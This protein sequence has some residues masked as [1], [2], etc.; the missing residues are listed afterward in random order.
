[1]TA[2]GPD[3]DH[4]D[5]RL[6]DVDLSDVDLTDL[7]LFADGAPHATFARLRDAAPVFWQRP[8][9]HTP[10]GEG[11]WNLTRHDDVRWA[12]KEAATFSSHTGGGRAGGGTLI[13]DLPDGWA[14]GVL[15]NMQDDP[16]HHHL[17]RLITP[18]VSPRRLREVAD[19]LAARAATILDD[20]VARGRCDLLADVAVELPLQAIA[21]LLGIPQDDRHLVLGWA[22][23]TL[24]YEDRDLGETSDRSA[25]AAAEMFSYGADLLAAK[26]RCPA[27]DLLSILATAELPPE[28]AP[29][30]P[31]PDLEQQMF[32]NLLIAAGSETTR[33][34]LAAGLLALADHPDRWAAVQADRSLVA[35]TVE[36]MLRWSSSTTYNRRTATVDVDLHGAT[37]RAGDKVVLWWAAA[38]FD[39]RVFA[40]PLRFDVGRDPNPHLTFG[41]GT[42]F[43]LGAALARLEMR[44]VLEGLLDRVDGFEV[45]G[46]VIRTRSNKHTGFRSIPIR[47]SSPASRSPPSRGCG[48]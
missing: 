46:P 35:S 33:N 5:D 27:D 26:A 3:A 8:T 39:E 15:F 12:A 44:L 38:N 7:T 22:D 9:A 24:D 25:R 32:F 14:A 2:P 17:R 19:D 48:A 41:T 40:D 36:E 10:D 21:E 30:G 11:F 31:L 23:D 47:F 29:G 37:I 6:S 20:V 43:C 1:M 13:E 28:A 34:S 4:P 45:V 18:S 16:R 42:H